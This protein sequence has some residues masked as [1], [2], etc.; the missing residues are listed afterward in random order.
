MRSS[1]SLMCCSVLVALAASGC[2]RD[3]HPPLA[4][5]CREGPD[6]VV[7]A[8]GAAPKRVTLDGTS[9]SSC[10]RQAGR[11]G[12]SA[13]LTELGTGYV[14]AA[15]RLAREA[16]RRPGGREAGQLG[17]LMGAIRSV[18]ATTQGTSTELVRRIENEVV[19]VDEHTAAFRR[20]LR[21]GRQAG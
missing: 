5:A 19:R 4:Q 7:K 14:E 3:E 9:L 8:L 1:L 10:L 20:G 21:A 17:Y 13:E 2:A 6:A 12:N 18:S 11:N 15:S 16:E